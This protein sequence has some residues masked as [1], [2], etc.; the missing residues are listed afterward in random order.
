M[1]TAA[2][3]PQRTLPCFVLVLAKLISS[4]QIFFT[5]NKQSGPTRRHNLVEKNKQ[6]PVKIFPRVRAHR[7]PQLVAPKGLHHVL[8][9][10]SVPALSFHNRRS[11]VNLTLPKNT[12]ASFHKLNISSYT[13]FLVPVCIQNV[14]TG[15]EGAPL[16]RL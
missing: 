1:K 4:P 10:C 16:G 5:R 12:H 13:G 8:L 2:R 15:P 11:P 3:K 14:V 9:R 7:Q 6:N